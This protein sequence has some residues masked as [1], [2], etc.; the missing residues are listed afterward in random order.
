MEDN[1]AFCIFFTI[2]QETGVCVVVQVVIRWL[3][4]AEDH[5]QSPARL[6]EICGRQIATGTG[7]NSEYFV[8]CLSRNVHQRSR[9]TDICITVAI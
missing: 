3:L 1:L 6:C 7:F 5:V 9:L 2:L 8:F 4:I